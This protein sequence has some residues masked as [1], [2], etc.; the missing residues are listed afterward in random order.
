MLLM[1]EYVLKKPHNNTTSV[2]LPS[3]CPQVL[4]VFYD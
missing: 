1:K 4:K 3:N 2:C